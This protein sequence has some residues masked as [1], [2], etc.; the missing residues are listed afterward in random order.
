MATHTYKRQ[1]KTKQ[2]C[3]HVF[4]NHYDVRIIPNRTDFM[5]YVTLIINRNAF[6]SP[7]NY[8]SSIGSHSLTFLT[9]CVLFLFFW[10]ND[11]FPYNSPLK[12]KKWKHTEI[13]SIFVFLFIFWDKM[14]F[15]LVLSSVRFACR[16][17]CTLQTF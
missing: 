9:F 1:D 16:C 12:W 10:T 13:N 8:Y 4:W 2:N 7:F 11:F 5:S 15:F 17:R 3:P 14:T 6:F